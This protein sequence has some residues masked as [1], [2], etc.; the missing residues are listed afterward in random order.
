MAKLIGGI[1]SSHI[2]L[3]GHKIDSDQLVGEY[4]EKF[5]EGIIGGRKWIEE[6]QPFYKSNE[7]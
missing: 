7:A 4:W 6:N 5:N 1:G 2:P 3:I